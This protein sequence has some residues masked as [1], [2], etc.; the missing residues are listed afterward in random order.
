MIILEIRSSSSSLG[1][2]PVIFLVRIRS[3]SN[4][5][6]LDQFHHGQNMATLSILELLVVQRY[7]PGLIAASIRF[8]AAMSR[9]TKAP[10]LIVGL[11]LP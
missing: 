2:K 4:S 3:L 9:T 8:P 10:S 6:D 1:S 5:S 7:S 11:R